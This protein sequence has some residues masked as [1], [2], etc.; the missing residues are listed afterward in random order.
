[1]P[2]GV[3]DDIYTKLVG[4]AKNLSCPM[5]PFT[6]DPRTKSLI[7]DALASYKFPQLLSLD[8]E[9]WRLATADAVVPQFLEY[10]QKSQKGISLK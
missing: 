4:Q 2:K 7:R 6:L 10:L 5:P 3:K 8:D 1:V 9:P